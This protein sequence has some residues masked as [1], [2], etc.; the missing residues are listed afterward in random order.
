MSRLV[1]LLLPVLL[2][3]VSQAIATL[4]P[5]SNQS[6]PKAALQACNQ[7]AVSLGS[8]ILQTSGNSYEKA[9]TN[10]WNLENGQYQPTCIVFPTTSKHVQIAMKAIYA[11]K[12]HYA[13]QAGSHSAMKGWNTVQDGV[14]IIFSNM[15]EATYDP[16][17]DSITLGPGVHWHDAVTALEPF[18][19]APVGGR[20]G[21]VGTGLLLGGGL[22]WLSPSQGYATDNFKELDVVLVNGDLVTATATNQFSDLFRALK[23]GGDRF[24][25]VTRYELYPVHTGTKDEKN[26]FGGMLLAGKYQPIVIQFNSSAEAL[27]NATARYVREIDD[28]K[29]VLLST[30]SNARTGDSLAPLYLMVLFYNGVNLPEEIFGDFLSIPAMSST[31]GPMSYFDV[32]E[33][34]GLGNDRGYVQ[35][36]GASAL[37]GDE[38]T[39]L[40]AFDH[41]MN[42]TQAFQGDFN[43][44]T[45][46]FTPVPNSQIQA[47]RAKGGNIINAPHG[48]FAAVQLA[49]QFNAGLNRI[50]PQVLEGLDLLFEQI[51]PSPGLPLY[52]SECDPRQKVFESYGDY[53]LL[54]QIYAKYDPEK[55]NVKH[56]QGPVGL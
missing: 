46:A 10:A 36:F 40:E 18:G 11:A 19:V 5:E 37:V 56:T 45:L 26:W 16:V 14:L 31:L 41:W 34:L 30:F 13:V 44:T 24:G 7:L 12:S 38:E 55:F 3:L 27:L 23:G 1:S 17:K 4:F 33:T 20:V 48:G 43:I 52:L 35:R 51:P 29:A 28:P 32:S 21:D 42:F 2:L 49:E 39:Y 54:K 25:I 47:G 6:A 22:S 15:R 50:P 53:E 9:A 8:P